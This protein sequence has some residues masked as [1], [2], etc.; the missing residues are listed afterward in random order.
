M[1]SGQLTIE[2]VIEL[3]GEQAGHTV[4]IEGELDLVVADES[5]ERTLHG[6]FSSRLRLP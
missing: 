1:T 2:R 6:G 4:H 3:S 5:G